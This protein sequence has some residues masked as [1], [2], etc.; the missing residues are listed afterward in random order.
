MHR[1][2]VP[3]GDRHTS[4]AEALNLSDEIQYGLIWSRDVLSLQD[5]LV[6][7][8]TVCCQRSLH[9]KLRELTEAGTNNGLSLESVV[10]I[11]LQTGIYAGFAVT[12]SALA[13]LCQDLASVSEPSAANAPD[14]ETTS[15]SAKVGVETRQR[16]HGTRHS[17]GYADPVHPFA[18]PLYEIASSHCYGL[19][20]NRPGL[21]LRQRLICALAALACLPGATATFEK[22]VRSAVDNDMSLEEVVEIVMQT[23]PY[24]GF[25]GALNNLVTIGEMYPDRDLESLMSKEV[26]PS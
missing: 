12:E 16:L 25:P 9:G 24:A 21:N 5:R 13:E 20:W 14:V 22:F 2:G 4:V 6:V 3:N 26:S 15:Q 11:C 18:S 19:I 17:E 23:V 10:E 8:L 7:A 1:L